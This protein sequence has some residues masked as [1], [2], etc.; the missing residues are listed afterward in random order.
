MT[1]RIT[2]LLLVAGAALLAACNSDPS[3]LAPELAARPQYAAASVQHEVRQVS[4]NAGNVRANAPVA[5]QAV[6][7]EGRMHPRS[8]RYAMAAN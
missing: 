1:Q 7:S 4:A 8:S 6:K 2:K 3:I 5:E